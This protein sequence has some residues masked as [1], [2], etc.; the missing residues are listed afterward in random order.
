MEE[1]PMR[2]NQFPIGWSEEKVRRV[3]DY[4]EH[5]TEEDALIEDEA[6]IDSSDETVMNIPHELVSKVR[7]LIARHQ[8]QP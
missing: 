6:A 7:E 1:A 2:N 3:L 8:R 5:Q 4:Y